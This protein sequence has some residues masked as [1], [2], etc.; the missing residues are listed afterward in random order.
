MANQLQKLTEVTISGTLYHLAANGSACLVSPSGTDAYGNEF[1]VKV[2]LNEFMLENGAEKLQ[3][4]LDLL[5]RYYR[6]SQSARDR[7]LGAGRSET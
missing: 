6:E 5:A 3:A 7:V 2:D 4:L 1:H